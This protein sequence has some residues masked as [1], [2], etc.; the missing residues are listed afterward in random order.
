VLSL[1]TAHARLHS[2]LHSALEARSLRWHR[3]GRWIVDGVDLVVKPGDIVGLLGPNGAGKTVT[4]SM[5]V[6]MFDPTSG[7]ILID[8][9]DVTE[10]PLYKRARLGLGP[11]TRQPMHFAKRVGRRRPI[12]RVR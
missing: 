1:T 10:L 4:L 11:A 9:V 3:A 6:G 7:R 12:N 2:A 5:I 8:G